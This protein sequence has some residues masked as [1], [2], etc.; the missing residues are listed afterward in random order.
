MKTEQEPKKTG[1]EAVLFV[2]VSI[3]ILSIGLFFS[4]MYIEI[5]DPVTYDKWFTPIE[6]TNSSPTECGMVNGVSICYDPTKANFP[7]VPMLTKSKLT[8][9]DVG[10]WIITQEVDL[11]DDSID[12]MVFLSAEYDE[13]YMTPNIVLRCKNNTTNL[14]IGWGKSFRTSEDVISVFTRLGKNKATST[15]WS[16]STDNTATFYQG[17][18]IDFIKSMLE[19]DSLTVRILPYQKSPTTVVF[20]IRGLN[21]VIAPLRESCNW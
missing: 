21:N 20:D 19:V 7:T 3:I 8:E 13:R 15:N 4:M 5:N 2:M 9:V 6:T 11:I 16:L 1:I 14:Y 17:S 18:D 10:Q 12:V